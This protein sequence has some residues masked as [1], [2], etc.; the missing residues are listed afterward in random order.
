[1]DWSIVALVLLAALLHACWNAL[2]KADGDKLLFMALMAGGSGLIGLTLVPLVPVPAAASWPYIGA[3]VAL[4]TGYML[5]LVQAYRHGDLSQVYPIARGVAPLIVTPL[6]VFFA[7]DVISLT[8]AAAIAIIGLG[9][10]SLAFR[11]GPPLAHDPRPV[12]Y[13]LAT[14]LFIAAYTL[15]DGLGARLAGSPH[16]YAVWLFVLDGVPLTAIVLWRR[17]AVLTL[18]RA[19]ALPALAASVMSMTAYWLVIYGMTVAPIGPVAALRETSVI[20]A[21]IIGALMLKE[22]LGRWR[23]AAASLVAVGVVMLRI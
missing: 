20:F 2:I 9:V 6:A 19:K 3:S 10:A 8:S 17:R 22:G 4:H 11:G 5:F 21:A 14:A 13:A 7:G 12:A 23:I 1:M 15:T 18:A 16:A